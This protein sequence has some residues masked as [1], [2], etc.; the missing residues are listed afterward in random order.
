MHVIDEKTI[1]VLLF[2]CSLSG[3]STIASFVFIFFTQ[4]RVE[5]CQFS[6]C[7]AKEHES[8]TL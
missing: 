8:I 7:Q 6:S 5:M 4:S 1:V 3:L 2:Y